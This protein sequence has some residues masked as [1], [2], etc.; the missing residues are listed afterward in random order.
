[1]DMK[2]WVA[3]QIADDRKNPLPVLS[4]PAIQLMDITVA[5]LIGST[6][7]QAEAMRL[8]AERV[9][10]AASVSFMDLS[11]EAEAFGSEIRVSD[12]EVPTVIGS[13]IDD[14]TEPDDIFVPEVGAGRTGHYIEAIRTV[15]P[16]IN[17]RPV[18]A[19][20]I[21]P[22][23]LAGRLMDV[24]EV[25]VLCYEEPE[26]VHAVLDKVTGF[27]ADYAEAFKAA[28]ADGV[29]MAEP[30]AGLLPPALLGEFSTPYVK[31]IVDAV[32]TNEFTIIA[33]ARSSRRLMRCSRL[34]PRRIISAM[35]STWPTSCLWFPRESSPWAT[36]IPL[37]KFATVLPKAYVRRRSTSWPSAPSIPISCPRQVAMFPR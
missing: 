28:G 10:A 11:V 34:V 20:V 33:A 25:M 29:M 36:S 13:I 26:L 14:E 32:Q 18:F 15:A 27:I 1:M 37:A 4:F 21:G 7:K 24:N 19:G 17:D 16:L 2:K 31:R 8:V 5:D 3:E 22:F 9:D 6:E 30:L 12:D 23:S 35:R